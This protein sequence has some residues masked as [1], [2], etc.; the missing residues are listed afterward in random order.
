MSDLVIRPVTSDDAAD[1]TELINAIIARGGTTAFVE[2]FTPQS[3]S[4]QYLI[5]PHMLSAVVAVD[6]ET[7][8][9]EGFQ[10]LGDF[11][12][13]LPAKWGDIGTYVRVEGVQRGIGSQLFKATCANARALGLAGINATIRGDNEGGLA[14]YSKQGFEDYAVDRAV[15]LADG[16]VVDRVHKRYW[17]N[18]GEAG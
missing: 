10:I 8:R 11:G 2:P 16:T 6:T 12:T 14:F 13:P 15:P 18:E 7:C 4:E 3:L 17:L 5:G 9:A 1:L